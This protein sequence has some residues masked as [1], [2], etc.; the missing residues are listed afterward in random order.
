MHDGDT[1]LWYFLIER[2]NGLF[3]R[4]QK[5]SCQYIFCL[6]S[7]FVA[8]VAVFDAPPLFFF[9]C[10]AVAIIWCCPPMKIFR[11]S[12]VIILKL[13]LPWTY[14]LVYVMWAER[15]N[16]N[17]SCWK[18]V[19]FSSPPLLRGHQWNVISSMLNVLCL[20]DS[21]RNQH[22]CFHERSRLIY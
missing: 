20:L 2:Q 11:C 13:F 9:L 21:Y 22:Y 10:P 5:D 17:M 12:T 3:I 14:G 16:W 19:F 8:R 4:D 15:I 1:F 18:N 7:V 6:F